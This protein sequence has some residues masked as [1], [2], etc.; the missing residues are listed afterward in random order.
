MPVC[1]QLSREHQR[2]TQHCLDL[3]DELSELRQQNSAE[4]VSLER[5]LLSEM[6]ICVLELDAIVNVCVQSANGEEP[7][8]SSILGM[9]RK[10]LPLLLQVVK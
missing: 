5:Q 4:L 2:L 3:E 9:P 7:N 8:L 1:D 10:P 6:S